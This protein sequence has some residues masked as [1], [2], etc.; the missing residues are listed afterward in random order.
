MT[1]VVLNV[2]EHLSIVSNIS[3][4]QAILLPLIPNMHMGPFNFVYIGQTT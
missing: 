4:R 2:T 3:H 1:Q